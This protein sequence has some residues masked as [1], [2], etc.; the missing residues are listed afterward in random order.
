M[1]SVIRI[2]ATTLYLASCIVGSV[3]ADDK[4]MRAMNNFVH[5]HIECAAYFV[6]SS[7]CVATRADSAELSKRL[8]QSYEAALARGIEYGNALGLSQK[9][10]AARFEMAMTT[11]MSE[12][13]KS[14]MNISVI[15]NSHALVCKKLMNEPEEALSRFLAGKSLKD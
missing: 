5:Q 14:C 13:D 8:H 9:T 1:G 6:I 3:R 11:L 15:L 10:H 2:A 12:M 7:Q 4:E